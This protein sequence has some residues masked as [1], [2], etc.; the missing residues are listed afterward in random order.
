MAATDAPEAK[1]QKVEGAARP[2]RKLI[3]IVRWHA[4]GSEVVEW[5]SGELGKIEMWGHNID[6]EEA[7][8]YITGEDG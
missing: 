8:S 3:Y 7:K 1:K 2:A 6:I 4:P 5:D